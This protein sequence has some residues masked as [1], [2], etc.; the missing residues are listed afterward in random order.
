MSWADG[1]LGTDTQAP[2]AMTFENPDL[3]TEHHDFDV[4][5]G[6]EPAGEP[7]DAKETAQS[8]VGEREGHDR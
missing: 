2:R 6:L 8:E 4:L 5:V 1:I 7:D 3:A